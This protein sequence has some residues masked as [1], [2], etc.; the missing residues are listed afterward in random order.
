[1]NIRKLYMFCLIIGIVFASFFALDRY[2]LENQNKTVDIVLDLEE[3]KIM[4]SQ[5]EEDIEYFLSEFKNIGIETV[6][7]SETTLSILKE[8]REDIETDLDEKDLVVTSSDKKVL[9]FIRVGFERK[10]GKENVEVISENKIKVKGKATYIVY[11]DIPLM[12]TQGRVVSR[13]RVPKST[14]LEHIGI[15]FLD[16]DLELVKSMGLNAVLRPLYISAY[17]DEQSIEAYFEN[18]DYTGINPHYIIFSGGE[19]LGWDKDI[20][21]LADEIQK[22]KMVVGMIQN[23]GQTRPDQSGMNDLVKSLGYQGVRVLPINSYIQ[24]RYDLETQNYRHGEEIVNILYRA[25]TERNMRIIYFR[26]FID[27]Q[28]NYVEDMDIYS[29]RLL[30]LKNRLQ[31]GHNI[32]IGKASPM[33]AYHP[34]RIMHIPIVVAIIASLFILIDNILNLNY[35]ILKLLFISLS[36]IS[37]IIYALGIKID[38]IEKLLALLST[39]T[40]PSIGMMYALFSLKRILNVNSKENIFKICINCVKILIVTSAISLSGALFLVAI[41][42][43]IKYLIELDGFIGVKISQIVP[44]IS[45]VLIYMSAF[46]YKRMKDRKGISLEEFMDLLNTNIKILH[47]VTLILIAGI[48]IIFIARTGHQTNI[49]PSNIELLFRNV[50]ENILIARPRTK[51]FLIGNPAFILMVYVAYKNIKLLILPLSI[52]AVI[53]QSNILNT[54]SHI[55]APIYLSVIRTG[56]EIIFGSII[57]ICLLVSIE[58]VLKRCRRR[59]GYE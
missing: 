26:P 3:M 30:D 58:Y 35:K 16:T 8:N 24:N 52:V 45:T 23:V 53:G 40:L 6:A 47:V 2:K 7:I 51:A 12:N 43:D 36:S 22:R 11:E 4:A 33:N 5:S 54:F 18:L 32:K 57:G 9:N 31:K 10:L 42:S 28:G 13:Q 19:V 46:G 25:I 14:M 38:L 41:L 59:K 1:M 48:G 34:N 44:I 56:Y 50:L 49:K 37:S 15:G 29:Q 20:D 55:K 21:Y 27:A 17:E 39:I